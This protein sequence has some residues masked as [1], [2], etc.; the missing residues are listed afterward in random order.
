MKPLTPSE[1]QASFNK[2]LPDFVIQSA[3]ELIVENLDTYG[4][5]TFTFEELERKIKS[6]KPDDVRWN[7]KWL[8]IED[9]FRENGWKVEVDNPGYNETYKGN[10]KFSPKNK[11]R[12]R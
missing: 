2:S 7:R 1:A 4:E 3:N 10:F 11:V 6:K 8:D 9:A 12:D 5:A